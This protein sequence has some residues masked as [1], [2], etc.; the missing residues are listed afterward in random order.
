[1]LASDRESI[2]KV[3]ERLAV[4]SNVCCFTGA[5]MSA[6]SGIPTFRGAGGLWAGHRVETVATPEAFESDPLLVWSFYN[7]RRANL[8][9]C[10]P[11]A[12]YEALV[13]LEG[14]F[15]KW[16]VITQNVDGLHR[17]AGSTRVIEIHGNIWVVR[18]SACASE[19]D[20][21]GERLDDDP[22]CPACGGR[23]RPGVVWFGEMLP[24]DAFHAA[25]A[26]AEACA[27]MLVIGTSGAVQPAASLALSAKSS[28]AYVVEIGP[29]ST[30]LSTVADD[31]LRMP[32]GTALPALAERLIGTEPPS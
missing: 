31:V 18:C 7:A 10:R 16:T 32:A 29:D 13:K 12:G 6:E 9:E 3:R 27:A 20:R 14:H 4:V 15:W 25:R 26:A 24:V 2:E 28:G 19:F 17:Q 5:G 11:H 23:L 21:T 30:E 22:R 8:L 1:M